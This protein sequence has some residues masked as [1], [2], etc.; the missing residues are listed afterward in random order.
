MNRLTFNASSVVVLGVLSAAAFADGAPPAAVAAQASAAS[1]V[2]PAVNPTPAHA[3]PPAASRAASSGSHPIVR[4]L[5]CLNM[6]L[7]CF[8]MKTSPSDG[9]AKAA[10]LDLKA[11]EIHRVISEVQL[12]EPLDEPQEVLEEQEQVQVQG[13]RP[14]I[15]LPIG[16]A[17]LPWAVM[18]PTQAWRIFLPV[19]PGTAK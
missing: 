1:A 3:T 18:H 14:E 6:S 5:V 7:Q 11:P 17:S 16:I 15:D 8:A 2:A 12:R 9:P 10:P 19:P 4:K 13:S